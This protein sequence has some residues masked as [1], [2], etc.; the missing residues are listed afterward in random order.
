[1]FHNLK[2]IIHV[3]IAFLCFFF[4]IYLLIQSRGKRLSNILLALF[5]ITK[6]VSDI[7]GVIFHF[8]ELKEL[9]ITNVPRLYYLGIPF[10]FINIP[11]LYLYILSLTQENFRLKKVYLLHAIPFLFFSV[12]IVRF[13]FHDVELIRTTIRSASFFN[14]IEWHAFNLLISL[15]FFSY[16]ILSLT[17][18]KRYRISIK[19]F[20][21][22][23]ERISLSWLNFVIW[24]FITYQLLVLLE[25]IIWSA[26][27]QSSPLLI[28]LYIFAEIIFL[29]FICMIIY[30]ALDQ[31]EIFLTK[32][33]LVKANP[34][35]NKIKYEKNLLSEEIKE[36]YKKLLIKF[37]RTEKPYLDSTLCLDDI[38]QK[39][40]IPNH[41]LSQIINTSFKQNFFDFINTY[42][43]EESKKLLSENDDH[44]K[45]ILEV[46]YQ[47]GFNSKSVFN[48]AF[49]KY[50]GITPTQFRR[51]NYPEA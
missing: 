1:M 6:A 24:G 22:N 23:V 14:D 42:R 38:A 11:L 48:S 43:I 15:Q 16:M 30:K 8:R 37:M 2:Y 36:E 35:N 3:I 47:S 46:L 17:L 9:I 51:N 7:S 44:K 13:L 20:F 50:T 29:I 26:T 5:L 19:N 31:P 45:T 25:Y 41:H 33:S 18:V 4:S 32:E 27:Q 10:E 12:I 34:E 39:I 21:S 28:A 49:K 40:S